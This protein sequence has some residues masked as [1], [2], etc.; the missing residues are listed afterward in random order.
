MNEIKNQLP[1]RYADRASVNTIREVFDYIRRYRGKTFVLKIEDSLLG[2]PLFPLL[3]KD[4]IQ[5]H[6]TGVHLIIVTGTR[7]TIARNLADAGIETSFV[8]GIRITP[9]AGAAPHQAGCHGGW[10]RSIISHLAAGGANG[11]MGNWTKGAFTGSLR[12]YRFSMDRAGGKNPLG[13]CPETALPGFYSGAVQYWSQCQGRRL[14][15]QLQPDCPPT[16]S[17]SGH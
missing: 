12:R 9:A 3:M 5:L 7:A 11:I 10:S 13:Y 16:L 8:K 6:D 2:H 14:Q 15:S 4:I 17:G 1:Q